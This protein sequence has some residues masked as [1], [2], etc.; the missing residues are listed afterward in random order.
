MVDGIW[1]LDNG[2]CWIMCLGDATMLDEST[3]S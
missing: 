2:M 1:M 3:F